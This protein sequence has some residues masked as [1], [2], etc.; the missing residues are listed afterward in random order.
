MLHYQDL[1]K[2][3]VSTQG[4]GVLET[5]LTKVLKLYQKGLS[6]WKE[7]DQ[8]RRS[9][10]TAEKKPEKKES[11]EKVAMK[12]PKTVPENNGMQLFTL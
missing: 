4:A 6:Y 10:Q 8:R 5:H 7:S 9:K 12:T 11:D 3:Q 2:N 1:V